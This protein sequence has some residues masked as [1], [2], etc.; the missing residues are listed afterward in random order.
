[1]ARRLCYEVCPRRLF[2]GDQSLIPCDRI[3]LNLRR[4]ATADTKLLIADHILPHACVDDHESIASQGEDLPGLVRSL[5]PEDSPLLPN[6]G[7]ANAIAYYLDLTVNR[8]A[9]YVEERANHS[10]STR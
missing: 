2:V 1:M 3:L 8:Y 6:L 10:K 4:A 7:K 5:A 9:V